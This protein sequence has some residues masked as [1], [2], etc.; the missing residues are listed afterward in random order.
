MNISIIKP[1]YFAKGYEYSDGGIH[2][3]TKDEMEA[4]ESYGGE[5]IFTPGDIIYSSSHIIET[6][7]PAADTAY[8]PGWKVVAATRGTS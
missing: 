1:D 3:R 5:I 8:R 4:L 7:P 6:E 2:P